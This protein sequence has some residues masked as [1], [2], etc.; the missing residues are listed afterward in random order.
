[1]TRLKFLRPWE[2]A[3][4][5]DQKREEKPRNTKQTEPALKDLD[6]MKP[7]QNRRPRPSAHPSL[8]RTQKVAGSQY[9]HGE[10]YGGDREGMTRK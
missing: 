5:I 1:M 10:S 4:T 7:G 2:L 6:K 3:K 9:F 8:K